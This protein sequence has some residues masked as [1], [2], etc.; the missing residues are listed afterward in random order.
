MYII[1]YNVT[2]PTQLFSIINVAVLKTFDIK[3]GFMCVSR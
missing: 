1:G 3:T 2:F